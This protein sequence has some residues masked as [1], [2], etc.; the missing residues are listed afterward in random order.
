MKVSRASAHHYNW[1]DGCDGWV[2]L[3]DA[4]LTIIEE[5]MPAG[6]TE[7]RH[8]HEKARQFFYVL[9]GTFTM[10][11]DGAIHTLQKGE[12]I[13]IPPGVK[14]QAMNKSDDVVTFL[15]ASSPTTHGDRVDEL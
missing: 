4:G 15:V 3:P 9:S 2:L 12:G 1:G 11:L 14:H 5:K 6:T 7:Q 8:H 10:E 13:T